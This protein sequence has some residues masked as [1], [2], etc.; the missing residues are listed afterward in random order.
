[1]ALISSGRELSSASLLEVGPVKS[2]AADG[3][4]QE[5]GRPNSAAGSRHRSAR[6]AAG[7]GPG[8]SLGHVLSS[9]GPLKASG[10]RRQGEAG[11]RGTARL[12]RG[13]VDCLWP[14]FLGVRTDDGLYVGSCTPSTRPSALAT[15]S[16]W[17]ASIRR[18]P[19]TCGGTG[20]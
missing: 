1:M 3:E 4:R 2:I 9:P 19:G 18:R 8:R 17:T 20:S 14:S 16:S 6:P 11:A 5:Q 10:A 15:T 12:S 7:R 13:V